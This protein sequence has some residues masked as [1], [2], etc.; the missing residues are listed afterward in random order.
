MTAYPGMAALAGRYDGFIL[1]LW[2][3][4]HDGVNPYEGAGDCLRHLRDAGKRCVLLSN[5]PRRSFAAEAMLRRMGLAADL[6]TGI[7]TSGEAVHLALQHR[8]DPW[9]A[10]LG[11]RVWHLGPERDRNVLDGLDLTLVETP[12]EA[13]FVLNTGPDDHRAPT[14][15]ALFEDVLTECARHSLPMICANP[16]LEVIR[17]GTRVICAGALAERYQQLGG[18]VRSL[19]KPDPAIYV[20]VMALLG[21]QPAR[22]LAVGDA[23]RTDIAGA[24]AA[25]VDSCWVLGGIH[26]EALGDDHGA[27]EA[28]ARAAGLHPVAI[29][30][31]FVW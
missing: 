2:G 17:G 20:P 9:F 18:A 16:D 7:L 10:A 4:I 6:Y 12:A 15:V 11:R 14:D 28:E 19:G 5:A 31:R 8:T 26:G 29:I 30:P 24:A 13:E 22:T 27:A 21:C 23:L 3:V 25:G 1:D